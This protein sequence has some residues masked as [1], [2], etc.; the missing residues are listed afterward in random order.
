MLLSQQRAQDRV[1]VENNALSKEDEKR[2]GLRSVDIID[3]NPLFNR[4]AK[5]VDENGDPLKGGGGV[6]KNT[7]PRNASNLSGGPLENA[8][9]VSGRF[10][11]EGGLRAE[12]ST[13]LIIRAT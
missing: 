6:A 8:T 2:L 13:E 9:Q 4:T 1:V 12:L 11:I 7:S 3:I 10:K 5:I